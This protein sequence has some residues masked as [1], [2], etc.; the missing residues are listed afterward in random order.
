MILFQDTL[1][2]VVRQLRNSKKNEAETIADAITDTKAELA[3]NVDH[4]KVTAVIKLTY[5]AMLGYSGEY[6]AFNIIE[7]M[8]D[9]TFQH[10]RAGYVAAAVILTENTPVLPLCTALLKRDMASGN[11]YEVGLALYALSCVA[12][13][14][15]AKDLISDVVNLTASPR[16]YV[17]KKAV[18]CLYK[19]F[20]QFPEALRLTYP[21]LKEKLE[22][23]TDKADND[24]SVRGAVVNVLTELARRAPQNFLNLVPAFYSL[25]TTL[26]NN[27]S[28]I[29][30]VKCFGYFAPIEPRLGKK[31]VEPMTNIITSTHAKSVQYE[32]LLAV[33]NGMSKVTSLTKLAADR[34]K[35]FV[36]DRDANLKYLGLDAMSRLMLDNPKLVMDQ[37]DTVLACLADVDATIRNKALVILQGLATKKNLVATINAMFDNVTLTPPDEEWSNSVVK[38]I[39]ETAADDDYANV[40]DFEWYLAVLIDLS[41]VKLQH[42]A[43]GALVERE[44]VNVISRV[45]AVRQ[46]GVESL[47]SLLCNSNILGSSLTQSTQWRVLNAAAYL[48]GEFPYWLPNKKVAVEYLLSER[49]LGMPPELQAICVTAA[50][51]VY[52]YALR[53]C[54]RHM[55]R[56]EGEEECEAHEDPSTLADLHAYLT[57]ANVVD[58]K[59][60]PTSGLA[61]FARNVDANVQERAVVVTHLVGLGI[62]DVDAVAYQ[63]DFYATELTAVAEGAQE[64]VAVPDGLDLDTPFSDALPL[65]V[66]DADGDGDDSD[67]SDVDSD[68]SDD[69][70]VAIARVAKERELRR[71]EVDAFYLKGLTDTGGAAD[72][73]PVEQI[74]MPSAPSR[75][76]SS[77]KKTHTI[78]RAMAGPGGFTGTTSQSRASREREKLSEPMDDITAKL[79]GIRVDGP[80]GKDEALPTIQPYKR[81]DP[82]ASPARGASEAPGEAD[83]KPFGDPALETKRLEGSRHF[84][85]IELL[86]QKTTTIVLQIADVKA[87]KDGHVLSVVCSVANNATANSLY[88]VTLTMGEGQEDRMHFL[89]SEGTPVSTVVLAARVKPEAKV[90]AEFAIM[91]PRIQVLPMVPLTVS[92]TE[93]KKAATFPTAFPIY[94]KYYMKEGLETTS[95][96]FSEKVLPAL[97]N[98]GTVSIAIPLVG[99]AAEKLDRTLAHVATRLRLKVVDVYRD[100]AAL[101]GQLVSRKKAADA[102]VAVVLRMEPEVPAADGAEAQPA[103][104]T[105]MVKAFN[106][107]VMD[108]VTHEV[109][110]VVLGEEE[111]L[112]IAE[113]TT[114]EEAAPAA[115]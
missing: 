5:F 46:Y 7:V 89:S 93:K 85:P 39:I 98:A 65:L 44:F 76:K 73:P 35:L 84:H 6:G 49:M 64:H 106:Q 1:A 105:V 14:D 77:G 63:A 110:A 4:V 66:R 97:A 26:H 71:Q 101:H 10:K 108:G 103:S 13:P 92:I 32:C 31:L 48:C 8:A 81:L 75:F 18:L 2:D 88:D 29:K 59:A 67:D 34:I 27:W 99:G 51:K 114:G 100:T 22:D 12:N 15:L 60:H 9:N 30:V 95:A 90:A 56:I 43:H 78:S 62:A 68:D 82:S 3:S 36:E 111:A 33:A 102:D 94:T 19:L 61:A 55:H 79:G 70:E 21:K 113:A 115:E 17:R 23:G 104:L 50:G 80:I 112:A 28:L 38:A 40:T 52:A 41:Q 24:P 87:K 25:L 83:E 74:D 58:K 86:R 53:P 57:G 20:L 16:A 42:Y 109:T 54:T 96:E 37:R 45:R 91:L 69:N 72:L 107:G 47:A 11:Q